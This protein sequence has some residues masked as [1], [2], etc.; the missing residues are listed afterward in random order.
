MDNFETWLPGLEHE[1]LW[2]VQIF[3]IVL[4]SAFAN[5]FAKRGL[6]RM[7]TRLDRTRTRWDD[8]VFIAMSRPVTWVVWLV[9]L[10]AGAVEV[11]A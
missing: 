9:G 3:F 2:V 5:L 10:D 8:I 11:Y 6:A 1:W 7:L 4:I